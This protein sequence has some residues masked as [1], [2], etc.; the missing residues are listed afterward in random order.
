VVVASGGV[1]CFD[2]GLRKRRLQPFTNW[3]VGTGQY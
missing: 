1:T 3:V 2:G